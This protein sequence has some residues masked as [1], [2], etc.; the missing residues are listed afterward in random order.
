[1]LVGCII[2]PSFEKAKSQ[3]KKANLLCDGIELRL[4]FLEK[5]DLEK[6]QALR[7]LSKGFC[8]FTHPK[9]KPDF[10]QKI[11]NFHPD[12]L[13]LPW[14]F[15]AKIPPSQPK[16]IR[17]S[18]NFEKTPKNLEEITHQMPQADFYKICTMAKSINDS[19]RMLDFVK[20]TKNL[21]GICM[22]EQGRMTRI[23]GPVVG[24]VF[25]YV[26][27]DEICAPGQFL[28]KELLQTYNYRL[29]N[30]KTKIYGLIGN[31]TSQSPSHQTHNA[32]FKENHLNAIYIKMQIFPNELKSF[33]PLAKKLGIKG[34]SVTIPYKEKLLF[35]LDHI[36]KEAKQ[37]GAVNTLVFSENKIKG[38]NTDATAA[39]DVIEKK[40][41]VFQKKILLLG[42]GGAARAI[43][44]EA[45][46]RNASLFIL[47]R[48]LVRAKNLGEKL[49]C[50]YG[51]ME[52]PPNFAYDILIN[53]TPSPNPIELK[54]LLP[55]TLIMDINIKHEDTPFLK[56][57]ISLD[58]QVILGKEMFFQ[59]AKK[60]FSYWFNP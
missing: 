43:A 48:T 4:D 56:A 35:F 53:A 54:Y 18:H 22:G 6:I 19:L 17:S 50:P 40:M 28:V 1:M 41:P 26:A 59:Q 27:I 49:Q 3:I 20:K 16:I 24:N 60:Q 45:K 14:D 32:F 30:R 10:L 8:I 37:I 47:S 11:L 25:D 44:F 2:G 51:K 46:K 52:D 13:D 15:P 12:Y 34:L 7:M 36:E 39:L 29:L 55:K 42:A 5:L 31:P 58:C 33:F 38:Y 21:T 23:L 9:I 57:A